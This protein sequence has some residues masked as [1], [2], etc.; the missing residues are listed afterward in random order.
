MREEIQMNEFL[1][2]YI[3]SVLAGTMV[4]AP[5]VGNVGLYCSA[6]DLCRRVADMAHVHQQERNQWDP[7]PQ[8]TI[9]RS[10]F[11]GDGGDGDHTDC[12]VASLNPNGRQRCAEMPPLLDCMHR[13]PEKEYLASAWI[14]LRA[15]P[16]ARP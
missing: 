6:D 11:D 5:V 9:N 15:V 13:I 2:K 16:V 10:D 1:K 14:Y 3:C 12:A 4:V 7:A 8:L